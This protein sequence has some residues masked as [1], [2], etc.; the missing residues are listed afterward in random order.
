[1]YLCTFDMHV[2]LVGFPKSPA[3]R[4]RVVLQ[5]RTN[6]LLMCPMTSPITSSVAMIP[7]LRDMLGDRKSQFFRVSRTS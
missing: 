7:R 6:V 4:S 2:Q 5:V 3:Y 1:M